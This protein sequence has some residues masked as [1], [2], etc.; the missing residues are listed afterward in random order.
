MNSFYTQEEALWIQQ[1]HAKTIRAL[2]YGTL[3]SHLSL[4]EHESVQPANNVPLYANETSTM[5]AYLCSQPNSLE[6]RQEHSSAVNSLCYQQL[7]F[8]D[9]TNASIELQSICTNQGLEPVT[10]HLHKRGV[11]DSRKCSHCNSS[12]SP[13]NLWRRGSNNCLLCNKCGLKWKRKIGK[14]YKFSIY[15]PK[16]D[17][18]AK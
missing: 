9:K 4:I 2:H 1:N 16:L 17:T 6:P 12:H 15:K 11:D 3:S 5:N 13:G 10:T 8:S 18:R 14:K 7:D